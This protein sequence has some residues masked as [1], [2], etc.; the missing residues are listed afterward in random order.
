MTQPSNLRKVVHWTLESISVSMLC[1]SA[2]PLLIHWD[3]LPPSILYALISG[4]ACVVG[5]YVILT[6][7][8]RST[9]FPIVPFQVDWEQP[10][11]QNLLREMCGVVKALFLIQYLYAELALVQLILGRQPYPVEAILPVF[12]LTLVGSFGY[13]WRQLWRYKVT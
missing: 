2:I 8:S 7:A 4:V 13:Y 12:A 11:A 10:A 5:F 9:T 6:I 3:R 1:A